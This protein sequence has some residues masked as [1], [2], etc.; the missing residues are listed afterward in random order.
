MASCA[1]CKR[2]L[3]DSVSISRGY[4]PTCWR[5]IQA[6]RC[7]SGTGDGFYTGGDIVLRRVDG[8]VMTNV[9]HRIVYH[10]PSGFEFGY[11]GSGPA[12]LAL[13]ILALFTD[14]KTAFRLHQ[15]FK[16]QFIATMP[17]EGGVIK[18][19]DIVNWLRERDAGRV[20]IERD[21]SGLAR[22]ISEI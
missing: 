15:D 17:H 19:E 20:V 22:Y 4:G 18:R 8:R 2:G 3:K 9:P 16:W 14:E 12:D 21:A 7:D 10:S 13:N 6:S 11:G 5:K 1:R